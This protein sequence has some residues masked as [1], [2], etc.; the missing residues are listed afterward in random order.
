MCKFSDREQV[1]VPR[2]RRVLTLL[3]SDGALVRNK[4]K[5]FRLLIN[6]VAGGK[7]LWSIGTSDHD[8]AIVFHEFKIKIRWALLPTQTVNQNKR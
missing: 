4:F 1:P 6:L 3:N 2:L 5:T 7:S 8:I